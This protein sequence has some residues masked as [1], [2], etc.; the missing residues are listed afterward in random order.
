MRRRSAEKLRDAPRRHRARLRRLRS[1][2]C[3]PPVGETE[4][5]SINLGPEGLSK[6]RGSTKPTPPKGAFA[7]PAGQQKKA[8]P[9]WG[10]K[11]YTVRPVGKKPDAIVASRLTVPESRCVAGGGGFADCPIT[12]DSTPVPI[13]APRQF[14]P[15]SYLWRSRFELVRPC[16]GP[17]QK[18]SGM[19]LEK[20]RGDPGGRRGGLTKMIE[21][22]TA[23][24]RNQGPRGSSFG[25]GVPANHNPSNHLHI[26]HYR[27]N[28]QGDQRLI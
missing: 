15:A 28:T 3:W 25:G 27:D 8:A 12:L 2:Q 19:R 24:P 9:P 26:H 1:G 23:Q 13:F 14:G 17:R 22:G 5:Q 21:V 11:G 10:W 6:R 7:Q 16:H 4:C 20:A 18:A